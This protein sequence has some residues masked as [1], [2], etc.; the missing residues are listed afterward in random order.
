MG[1]GEVK[2]HSLKWHFQ[3]K[4]VTILMHDY[5]T[6]GCGFL[7][8]GIVCRDAF[9]FANKDDLSCC[10]ERDEFDKMENGLNLPSLS[11]GLKNFAIPL[12]QDPIPQP[13]EDCATGKL[14]LAFSCA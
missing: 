3:I 7:T 4:D 14:F 12:I 11:A 6:Y 10:A 5:L 9:R 8:E 13:L 1:G 2:V